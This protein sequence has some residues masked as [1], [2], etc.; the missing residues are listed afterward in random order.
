MYETEEKEDTYYKSN[1][2][3]NIVVVAV[4]ITFTYKTEAKTFRETVKK[5]NYHV[6]RKYFLCMCI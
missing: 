5:R 1:I 3:I 4:I 2:N 6:L